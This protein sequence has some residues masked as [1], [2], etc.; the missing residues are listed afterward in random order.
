MH[1]AVISA[2]GPPENLAIQQRPIPEVGP[3][4]VLIRVRAA[5]INR[6]DIFQRKGSYPAPSGVVQDIPGLEVAGTVAA[7]G[8]AVTG[9]AT[10][11]R[12]CAL[13]PGG[14][15]AEYVVAD[16]RHG[17]PIPH[18]VD[19]SMAACLPETTF[20]VWHNL[21]QLGRLKAGEVVLVHGGSGGI[22]T[23]A[24]QLARS[25]GA[26]VYATAGSP[27]KCAFC[28]DLGADR[29]VNYKTEDFGQL[30]APRSI[31]VILDSIGGSY[32]DRNM[33]LLADDGRMVFINA[34]GGKQAN[35]DV[36]G[37]MQRRITLTGSTLRSRDVTFKSDLREAVERCV[38][39]R[40]ASGA[41]RPII[42]ETFPLAEAAKAHERMESGD[43]MG[44]L[45]LVMPSDG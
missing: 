37:L 20:T 10:G 8:A 23:M 24:I 17:L 1:A 44:K 6:P 30:L 21:F 43:F 12:I 14:G 29:C 7:C 25:S 18:N 28:E 39:P 2:Y 36:L 16:A 19:F 45:V 5:G 22:G 26:T 9:W 4:D 34:T 15:Y 32:F 3:W 31:D 27:E 40:V 33:A 42:H 38:W 11:D 13:V 41:V 35:L